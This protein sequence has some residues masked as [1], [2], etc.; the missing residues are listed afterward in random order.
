MLSLFA[1]ESIPSLLMVTGLVLVILSVLRDRVCQEG[2]SCNDLLNKAQL[3]GIIS[4]VSAVVLGLLAFFGVIEMGQG[5]GF[6]GMMGGYGGGYG[7]YG[8]GYGGYY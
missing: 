4:L 6:G 5:Y 7:G 2:T 1:V 3:P 8:G